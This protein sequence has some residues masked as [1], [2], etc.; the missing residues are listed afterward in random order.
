MKPSAEIL[1]ITSKKFYTGIIGKINSACMP[2]NKADAKTT[3]VRKMLYWLFPEIF[4]NADY[5]HQSGN[6]LQEGFYLFVSFYKHDEAT[7]NYSIH[8]D[9]ILKSLHCN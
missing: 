8:P 9:K 4:D 6:L 2:V 5:H 3:S 7:N 1:I